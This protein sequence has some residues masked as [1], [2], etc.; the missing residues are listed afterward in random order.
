MIRVDLWRAYTGM[1]RTLRDFKEMIAKIDELEDIVRR[2]VDE[3]M[4]TDS[5]WQNIKD[6]KAGL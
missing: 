6:D 4:F 1:T 2:R 5:E 3:E